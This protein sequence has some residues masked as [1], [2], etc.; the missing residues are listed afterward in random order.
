VSVSALLRCVYHYFYLELQSW[1]FSALTCREDTIIVFTRSAYR[2]GY[3]VYHF[4]R[5]KLCAG[6]ETYSGGGLLLWSGV[7]DF[8]MRQKWRSIGF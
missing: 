2:V 1:I 8:A 6:G 5:A 4:G 7:A 3:R